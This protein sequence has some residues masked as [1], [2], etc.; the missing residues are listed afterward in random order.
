[1]SSEWGVAGLHLQSFQAQV[2]SPSIYAWNGNLGFCSLTGSWMCTAEHFLRGRNL[3]LSGVQ[4]RGD[5]FTRQVMTTKQFR[6]FIRL[7]VFCQCKVVK[8][9]ISTQISF[10]FLLPFLFFLS[11]PLFFLSFLP[12]LLPSPP[13]LSRLLFINSVYL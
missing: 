8:L 2:C 9:D 11:S 5:Y 12:S 10:S 7:V 1:M 13:P 6:V 3:T 4:D